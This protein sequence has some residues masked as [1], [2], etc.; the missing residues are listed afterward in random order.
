MRH[1]YTQGAKTYSNVQLCRNI[2]SHPDFTVGIGISPIQPKLA[3]FTA[4]R[5]SHPALKIS[6]LHQYSTPGSTCQAPPGVLKYTV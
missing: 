6:N 4:G 2:F 3:D 1:G 5:E